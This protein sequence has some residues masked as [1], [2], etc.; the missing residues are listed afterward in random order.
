VLFTVADLDTLQVV[1]DIYER[2]LDLI[3]PGLTATVTVEAYPDIPFSS[4]RCGNR[5]CRR[6]EYT[7]DQ[8][9]SL[10]DNASH[11][12]KP[13]MFARLHIDISEERRSFRCPGS[14]PLKLMEKS[15]STSSRLTAIYQARS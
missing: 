12:L 7:Y 15:T 4:G 5:G 1:A 10:V 8:S 6:S 2:D 9:A 13:E 11:K 3:H 14:G